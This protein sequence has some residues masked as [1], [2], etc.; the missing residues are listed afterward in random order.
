MH[1]RRKRDCSVRNPRFAATRMLQ[2]TCTHGTYRNGGARVAATWLQL[3]NCATKARGKASC[4]AAARKYLSNARAC[5][6]AYLFPPPKSP[7]PA[8]GCIMQPMPCGGQGGAL[9]ACGTQSIKVQE[10]KE[11]RTCACARASRAV[12]I[13]TLAACV[14]V[15]QLVCAYLQLPCARRHRTRIHVQH[16]PPLVTT[17]CTSLPVRA[18]HAVR[19]R[20]CTL[21]EWRVRAGRTAA[22]G[23]CA[24][25]WRCV[26]HMRGAQQ[27]RGRS[28]HPAQFMQQSWHGSCA[29]MAFLVCSQLAHRQQQAGAAAG[30]GLHLSCCC[31]R[32]SH[33][34]CWRPASA[35]PASTKHKA[36]LQAWT[37]THRRL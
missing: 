31:T 11:Q 6:C 1:G 2:H 34:P 37:Y 24:W 25:K 18:P 3:T 32:L 33:K 5:V 13:R 12:K 4:R 16:R 7:T 27:A 15:A 10:V 17:A 19:V 20:V 36:V 30:A 23:A 26:V 28:H 29:W 8:H 14:R 22:L 9:P 21:W 35:A